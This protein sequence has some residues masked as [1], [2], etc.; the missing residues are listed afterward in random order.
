M[1]RIA[2]NTRVNGSRTYTY[3]NEA[4]I[5]NG[6]SFS[7]SFDYGDVEHQFLPFDYSR[8]LNNSNFDLVFWKNFTEKHIVKS[9]SSYILENELISS[10]KITVKNAAD[11]IPTGAVDVSLKKLPISQDSKIREREGKGFLARF[12]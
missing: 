12:F 2:K 1:D 11:T 6:K 8:I 3:S 4:E 7:V 10:F 9:G 5:K